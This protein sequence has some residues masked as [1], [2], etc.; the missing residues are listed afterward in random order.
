[1]EF[2]DWIFQNDHLIPRILFP[3]EALL[4]RDR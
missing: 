4:M 3:N 1:M 2:C